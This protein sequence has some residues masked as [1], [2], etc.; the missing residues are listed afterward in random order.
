MIEGSSI[1]AE[2]PKLNKLED[3]HSLNSAS[4]SAPH[5]PLLLPAH[6]SS[7][8]PALLPVF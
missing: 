5:L 7:K 1:N 4:L 2:L 6:I 8:N 3:S